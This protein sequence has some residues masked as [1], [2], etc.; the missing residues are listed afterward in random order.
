[1]GAVQVKYNQSRGAH[2]AGTDVTDPVHFFDVVFDEDYEKYQVMYN[3]LNT[4]KKAE[5][6]DIFGGVPVMENSALA[7]F[8]KSQNCSEEVLRTA[9]ER[10]KAFSA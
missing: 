8:W 2:D 6:N 10:V 7:G 9:M 4:Q 1:M 3:G 5:L